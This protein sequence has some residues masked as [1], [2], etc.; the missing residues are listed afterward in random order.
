[1][2]NA[3]LNILKDDF[4]IEILYW[5]N[6]NHPKSIFSK[7]YGLCTNFVKYVKSR[8][9]DTTNE[10]DMYY[11]KFLANDFIEVGL[12]P[13]YP[14]N[15]GHRDFVVETYLGK[16]YNNESRLNFIKSQVEKINASKLH[17]E[18]D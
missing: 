7:Q 8:V 4:Y 13:E 10:Y 1:M 2:N 17:N 6:R 18:D 12:F 16:L 11:E 5:I 14:F 3:E 9:Y 15:E